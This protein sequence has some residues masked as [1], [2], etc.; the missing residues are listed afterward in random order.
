[1]NLPGDRNFSSALCGIVQNWHR[2]KTSSEVFDKFGSRQDLSGGGH[3]DMET[4]NVQ[5]L[6]FVS[7]VT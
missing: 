3:R 7:L 4:R 6:S 1:M 5:V 2:H